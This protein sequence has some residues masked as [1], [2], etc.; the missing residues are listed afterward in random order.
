[1]ASGPRVSTTTTFEVLAFRALPATGAVAVLELEGRFAA[2]SPRELGRPSLLLEGG[3]TGGTQLACAPVAGPDAAAGPGGVPWRAAFAVPLTLLEDAAFALEVGRDL[4]VEL[5]EP[6]RSGG[7]DIDRLARLA[8]EGNELRRAL[9]AAEDRARR[10]A[11]SRRRVDDDLADLRA[12]ATAIAAERDE[13]ISAAE[14]A[15][16]ERDAAL[17]AAAA[18]D[19]ARVG[20]ATEHE[21]ALAAAAT[22]HEQALAAAATEHEQALAAAATEREQALAAAAI[23]R[24]QALAAERSAREAAERERD[25]ARAEAERRIAATQQAAK[26]DRDENERQLAEALAAMASARQA[27]DREGDEAIETHDAST[28]QDL[29]AARAE[30]DALRR[31][32][33]RAAR[34]PDEPA[35]RRGRAA[36]PG[37]ATAAGRATSGDPA[38]DVTAPLDRADHPL[39]DVTVRLIAGNP[40]VRHRIEDEIEP[41][42]LAPGATASGAR[43]ITGRADAHHVL[44]AK[45]IGALVALL[46]AIAAFLLVVVLRIGPI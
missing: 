45:R 37:P 25:E 18:R 4:L 33:A 20:A 46:I 29:Q 40:R 3:G 30:L 14:A 32:P 15:A 16:A 23:E 1:M 24:E 5:P 21:Q 7:D 22:E 31:A 8:R 38:A 26:R 36:R 39:D 13:A 34:T 12:E 44:D 9:D 27:P 43:S 11:E 10:A 35:T 19:E 42:E 2:S 41:V 17:A 6:D 28:R